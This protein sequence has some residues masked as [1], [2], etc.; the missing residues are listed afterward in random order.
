M[1]HNQLTLSPRSIRL[2][3][4]QKPLH[5]KQQTSSPSN[6]LLH[7]RRHNLNLVPS[8]RQKAPFIQVSNEQYLKSLPE[9][10]AEEYLESQLFVEEPG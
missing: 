7:T 8:N 10:I 3:R 4:A 5:P 9:A 6:L 1:N 2:R